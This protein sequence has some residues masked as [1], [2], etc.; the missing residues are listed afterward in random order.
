MAAMND[1]RIESRGASWPSS[2]LY[3]LGML[4]VFV[5][6]RA[7]GSGR[8]RAVATGL[9]L[10]LVLAA[11]VVRG[12][13]LRGLRLRAS[14]GDPRPET[15]KTERALASL[16]GLG[17]VALAL[18]FVQ[19]DLWVS[20]AGKAL[21]RDHA[22][23]ATA[24]GALW[25]A[26]LAAAA[27]PILFG[28]LAYA[29]MTHAPTVEWGRAR[30][31]MLSGFGLG[32]ALVFAFSFAYVAAER[33]KKVDLSYFRTTRPSEATRKLVRAL[34]APVQIAY[35]FPPANEV[36]EEVERYVDDLAKESPKLEVNGYDQ[37]V[38]PAKARE[39]GVS[40]NG[41]LVIALGPPPK[42]GGA[43]GP[44]SGA[45]HEQLSLGVDLEGARNQLRN[46]DKEV[47]KRILQV[48]KPG[49][50]VY[51]TSGHGERR[52]DAEGDTDK[53]GT[54]RALRQLMLDQSYTVRDLGAAEG[55]ATD[56]PADATVVM[57]LGPTKP[58]LAEEEA[59]LARYV[60]RGGRLYVALD[61]EPGLDWKGL[62]TPLGLAFS[63]TVLANDQVYARRFYQPSDRTNL[64]TGSYSSHPSVATLG[65]LRPPVVLPGA[66]SLGEVKGGKP[67]GT[68]IDYTVHA[69]ASTWNDLDGNFQFDP[70]GETKKAWE[71]AAAVT[72]KS[73]SGK[74]EGRAVVLA[75]SDALT[76]TAVGSYGNPY[77]LL[78]ATK[79]LLGEEA[80]AGETTSEQDVAIAHTRNR[81]VAWFYSTI[82]LAP[83]L[84]LGAGWLATRRRNRRRTDAPSASPSAASRKEQTA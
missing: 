46:L 4:A 18:Y 71:L 14:A 78:D 43:A 6:E 84:V 59:S 74:P 27:L 13:R 20:V 52:S 10:A 24:I 21:D 28:E 67:A 50:T 1:Q 32:F 42:D 2:A 44:R 22:K 56:V 33:D 29:S 8:A 82:F 53:R 19:S 64:V 58:F 16:M 35:F 25:P 75:D 15:V 48:A 77:L 79:W 31:A 54:I 3:G 23:L 62:L 66:G 57:I 69:Q 40:G 65:H 83:A 72:R 49:R 47:Q 63:P 34:D 17:L 81:D 9:G 70:P 73:S 36:R 30:D 80:L 37:A 51:L 41:I 68:T 26:L 60:D 76:D 5:G 38:D 39:L 11:F 45:R 55:L 12:L 7:I 61:P